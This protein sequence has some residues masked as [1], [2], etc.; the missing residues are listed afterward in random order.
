MM[1]KLIQTLND[2]HFRN[3]DGAMENTKVNLQQS[4][5]PIEKSNWI[6]QLI[7]KS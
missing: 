5:N 6:E 3:E 4:V 1:L 2:L 7:A